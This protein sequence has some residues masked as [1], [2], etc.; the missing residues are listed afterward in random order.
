VSATRYDIEAAGRRARAQVD[1]ILDDA[2]RARLARGITMTRVAG[3]LGCSRQLIGLVEHRQLGTIDPAFLARYCAAV[4]LDVSVRAY[5]GGAPLRD[6]GQLRLL[7]RL[8]GLL[9]AGWAW[10]TEVPVNTEPADRRAIDAVLERSG[11]PVGIEAISRIGDAQATARLITLKQRAV[12]L[13]CMILLLADTRHNRAAVLAGEATLR[14]AFPS[15][16]RSVLRAL[17][18]G[19]PPVSNGIVFL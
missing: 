17:R 8:H 1:H 2:R 11:H 14:P 13:R 6:T 18:A 12:G 4:G 10:R 9:G 3:V 5:P 15:R 16:T 19:L 7:A